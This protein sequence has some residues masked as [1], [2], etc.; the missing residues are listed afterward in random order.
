MDADEADNKDIA[1]RYEVRSFPT[2]KFFPKGGKEPVM[3]ESGRS[4]PQ[5]IDVSVHPISRH[6]LFGSG[7]LIRL[8]WLRSSAMAILFD[9]IG[10]ILRSNSS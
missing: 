9:R 10:L 1:G 5:F 8:R 2:I 6:S 3:Y 4:E 7:F